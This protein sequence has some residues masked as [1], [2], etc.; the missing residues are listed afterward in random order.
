MALEFK[1]SSYQITLFV[2][3]NPLR[4]NAEGKDRKIISFED[5]E[6]TFGVMGNLSHQI[7][8]QR[9]QQIGQDKIRPVVYIEKKE[10]WFFEAEKKAAPFVK[11]GKDLLR[12]ISTSK[13]PLAEYEKALKLFETALKIQK[14]CNGATDDLETA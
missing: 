14:K 2:N 12:Q 1:T 10:L 5:K 11:Q 8:I 7:L 6:I 9:I 4:A 13:D 3:Q